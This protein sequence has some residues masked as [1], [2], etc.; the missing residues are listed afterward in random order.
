MA[1]LCKEDLAGQRR[2]VQAGGGPRRGAG[3]QAR[4]RAQGEYPV[5]AEWW[6]A[7][8]KGM[9]RGADGHWTLQDFKQ[10]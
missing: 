7:Q 5:P 1:L 6:S 4:R 10:I 2:R 9:V 8:H 3:E